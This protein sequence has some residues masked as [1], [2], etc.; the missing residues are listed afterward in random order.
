MS[1]YKQKLEQIEELKKEFSDNEKHE[2]KGRIYHRFT[3]Q[4][5]EYNKKYGKPYIQVMFDKN[6]DAYA[7]LNVLY[8][9]S[10]EEKES[11]K[12]KRQIEIQKR[13][14][15][16]QPH[17]EKIKEAKKVLRQKIKD[18]DFKACEEITENIEE[19]EKKYKFVLRGK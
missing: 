17:K 8:P 16:A 9:M 4:K 7:V 2:K 6:S 19:L 18:R 13:K 5:I 10:D 1:K 3:I 11:R 12:S 15:Q 14:E